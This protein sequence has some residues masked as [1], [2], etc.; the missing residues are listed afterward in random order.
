MKEFEVKLKFH[1]IVPQ[2]ALCLISFCCPWCKELMK[3]IDKSR[4]EEV[5][6]PNCERMVGY[7]VQKGGEDEDRF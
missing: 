1:T 5:I 2:D 4:Y 7:L 6:C 3:S